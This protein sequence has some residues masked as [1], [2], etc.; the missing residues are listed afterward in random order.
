MEVDDP[1]HQM[2][3]GETDRKDDARILVDSGGRGAVHDVQVLPL[4]H[5][6]Q[7]VRIGNGCHLDDRASRFVGALSVKKDD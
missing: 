2:E 3:T 4:T 1:I 7:V 6:R 5:Q